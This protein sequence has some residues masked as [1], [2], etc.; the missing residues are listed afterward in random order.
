ML[1]IFS[2]GLSLLC[3]GFL[4]RLGVLHAGIKDKIPMHQLMEIQYDLMKIKENWNA[5]K[6]IG[7]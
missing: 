2:S 7:R 5:G 3:G 6:G 4:L 1:L